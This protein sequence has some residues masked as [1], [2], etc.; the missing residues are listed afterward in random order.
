MLKR[1]RKVVQNKLAQMYLDT[2]IQE[3]AVV[4]GEYKMVFKSGGLSGDDWVHVYYQ[5]MDKP[6][7]FINTSVFSVFP[8]HG[9][10]AWETEVPKLNQAMQEITAAI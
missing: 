3:V 8:E 5:D 1:L 6:V 10:P 7:A 2:L 9:H 4:Q